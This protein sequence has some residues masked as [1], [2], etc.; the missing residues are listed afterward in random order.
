MNILYIESSIPPSRGG[1]QRVSW[2]ISQYL[3]SKGHDVF[4]AFFLCDSDEIDSDHKVR[5]S[6][7]WSSKK[8]RQTLVKF[9]IQNKI[10]A[11]IC[12]D[13]YTKGVFATFRYIKQNNLCK[14]IS[15]FHLNPGYEKYSVKKFSM[16][17]FIK[18]IIFKVL[19][20][21]NLDI[22]PLKMMYATVDRLILLSSTFIDDAVKYYGL[23]DKNRIMCIPNPLSFPQTI[24]SNKIALKKKQVL[25]V[26]RFFEAQKNILSALNIWNRIENQGCND[27]ELVLGGYGPDEEMIIKKIKTLGLRHCHFVGKVENSIEMYERSQIFMMTSNYEGFGMTLTEA[28]QMGCIPLAFDNFSVLHDI[29]EDGYNGF[30]IPS[31][32]EDIYAK[33]LFG[34]M[35][36]EQLREKMI[37]NAIE[38]SKRFSIERV[39][40]QWIDLLNELTCKNKKK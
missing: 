37:F 36:N 6:S 31:G 25:I 29:I 17:H 34:L 19:K 16:K 8:V 1:I 11:I 2:V 33:K 24:E 28:L 15:C 12:Q 7:K 21:R 30:I 38:S 39:G 18:K 27:W 32:R 5:Y 22:I 4:F 26:T 40:E 23:P 35:E 9:I 14:I 3:K 10:D 20:H 13:Q